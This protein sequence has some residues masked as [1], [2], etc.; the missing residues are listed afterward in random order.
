MKVTTWALLALLSIVGADSVTQPAQGCPQAQSRE[1]AQKPSKAA[2][3]A[4]TGHRSFI[5]AARMGWL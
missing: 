5:I 1:Q 4:I 3:P 2:T